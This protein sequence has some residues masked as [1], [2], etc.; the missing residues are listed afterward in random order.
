[1]KMFRVSIWDESCMSLN[2]RE[3]QGVGHVTYKNK[4]KVGFKRYSAYMQRTGYGGTDDL[5]SDPEWNNDIICWS[6][7][8]VNVMF[9]YYD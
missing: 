7:M 8:A 4:K 6:I 2:T 1:M 5:N 9:V 3:K